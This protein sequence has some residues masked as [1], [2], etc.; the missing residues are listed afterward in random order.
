MWL[1]SHR[2]Q[3][4]FSGQ[5]RVVLDRQPAFQRQFS[6]LKIAILCRSAGDLQ[7][8]CPLKISELE[9]PRPI[10]YGPRIPENPDFDAASG[11]FSVGSMP[12]KRHFAEGPCRIKGTSGRAYAA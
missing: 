1:S 9:R 5:T 2:N 3:A 12:H 8:A 6:G 4:A 10:S 7:L 11:A